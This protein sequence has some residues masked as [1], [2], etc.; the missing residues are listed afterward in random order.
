VLLWEYWERSMPVACAM[1]VLLIIA[2]IPL[3]LLLRMFISHLN[4]QQ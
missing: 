4:R 3:T 2:L 1:G